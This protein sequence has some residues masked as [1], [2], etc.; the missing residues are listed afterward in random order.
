[1]DALC[2]NSQQNLIQ[3]CSAQSDADAP[4]DNEEAAD[5]DDGKEPEDSEK[6]GDA[7]DGDAKDGDAPDGDAKD[8]DAKDGDAKDGEA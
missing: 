7:K 4:E 3:T 5:G 6:E 2:D 1:M 8:G